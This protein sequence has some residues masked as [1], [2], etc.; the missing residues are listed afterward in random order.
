MNGHSFEEQ[1]SN[2]SRPII[3]PMD[4]KGHSHKE[5]AARVEELRA[6]IRR[7][8]HLYYVLD[9]PEIS[10]AEYDALMNELKRIEAEHP[11][12]VTP[13]SPTQRVG[14]KPAEGFQK[15]R[16]SRAMLSLDNAYSRRRAARLGSA[17]AR[18][19]RELAGGV[20]RPS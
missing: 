16:H 14:G 1:R 18:A 20:S 19:G 9:A 15:V 4:G 13:D 12:L 8:E 5:P 7:H 3:L 10:D 6:E 11:E 17:G 2:A